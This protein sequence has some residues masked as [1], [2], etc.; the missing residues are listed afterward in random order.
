MQIQTLLQLN[1]TDENLDLFSH[2]VL[3]ELMS[4]SVSKCDYQHA[5]SS[6]YCWYLFTE[7]KFT[8]HLT[9]HFLFEIN[10]KFKVPAIQQDLAE[11][12]ITLD[13]CLR[14]RQQA[15]FYVKQAHTYPYHHWLGVLYVAELLILNGDRIANNVHNR[16]GSQ[17]SSHFYTLYRE[18][19]QLHF[20]RVLQ[21]IDIRT[22]TPEQADEV[23]RGAQFAFQHLQQW[24][25][26]THA[27]QKVA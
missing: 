19:P 26:V 25:D 6:F 11:L 27:H 10:Y 5:L 8:Q 18:D 3:A 14:E 2:P 7:G 15:Y 16:L 20:M 9:T 12:N 17:T 13:R 4:V 22:D 24:L 23:I 21:A 1:S